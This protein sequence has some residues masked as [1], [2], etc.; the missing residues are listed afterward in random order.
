MYKYIFE[1][2]NNK[3]LFK[4]KLKFLAGTNL[5]GKSESPK[6]NLKTPDTPNDLQ[7]LKQILGTLKTENDEVNLRKINSLKKEITS[8]ENKYSNNEKISTQINKFKNTLSNFTDKPAATIGLLTEDYFKLEEALSKE[9]VTQQT[10]QDL[11]TLN[12]K[13]NFTKRPEKIDTNLLKPNTKVETTKR[14]NLRTLNQNNNDLVISQKNLP[15]GHPFTTTGKSIQLKN[16]GVSRTYIEVIAPNGDKGFII[17]ESLKVSDQQKSETS[18]T[19]KPETVEPSTASTSPETSPKEKGWFSETISKSSASKPKETKEQKEETNTEKINRLTRSIGQ[20]EATRFPNQNFHNPDYLKD[21]LKNNQVNDVDRGRIESSMQHLG[22]SYEEISDFIKN[23]LNTLPIYRLLESKPLPIEQEYKDLEK[24]FYISKEGIKLQEE[25]KKL[26]K[27]DKPQDKILLAQKQEEFTSK[28]RVYAETG[29]KENLNYY[30]KNKSSQSVLNGYIQTTR[31]LANSNNPDDQEQF[32]ARYEKLESAYQLANTLKNLQ[33]LEATEINRD[34]IEDVDVGNMSKMILQWINNP[35]SK[36]KLSQDLKD[37]I[38]DKLDTGLFTKK[39]K[40]LLL[41]ATIQLATNQNL[42]ELKR[43]KKIIQTKDGLQINHLA[44][45]NLE[46]DKIAIGLAYGPKL[47]KGV[48]DKLFD[49]DNLT[50]V[51]HKLQSS[52]QFETA[53]RRMYYHEIKN[54]PEKANPYTHLNV[55]FDRN[56]Y[57]DITKTGDTYSTVTR[58]DYNGRDKQKVE[59]QSVLRKYS[60]DLSQ[61]QQILLEVEENGII[62]EDKLLNKFNELIQLGSLGVDMNEQLKASDKNHLKKIATLPLTKEDLQIGIGKSQIELIRHG[63]VYEN[64][65]NDFLKN[66]PKSPDKS[67][68]KLGIP[69]SQVNSTY[70]ALTTALQYLGSGN[71]AVGK[72]LPAKDL[73][74]GWSLKPTGAAGAYILENPQVTVAGG[75]Q[76]K[77]TDKKSTFQVSLTGGLGVGREGVQAGVNVDT[78]RTEKITESLTVEIGAGGGLTIAGINVYGRIGFS[79]DNI[80][81]NQDLRFQQGLESMNKE[82][83]LTKE[84]ITSLKGLANKSDLSPSD[85]QTAESFFPSLAEAIQK[86]PQLK[87]ANPKDI[88]A[89]KKGYIETVLQAINNMSIE[90]A[91][92]VNWSVALTPGVLITPVGP[93]PYL[94]LGGGL[95]WGGETKVI[96]IFNPNTKLE[97]SQMRELLQD[98]IQNQPNKSISLQ[99]ND[100][101]AMHTIDGKTIVVKG[102]DKNIQNINIANKSES[103]NQLRSNSGIEFSETRQGY[104][105]FYTAKLDD[106]AKNRADIKNAVNASQVKIFVDPSVKDH[107]DLLPN[108]NASQEDKGTFRVSFTERSI[109]DNLVILRETITYPSTKG[110]VNTEVKISFTTKEHPLTGSQIENSSNNSS[111]LAFNRFG[112]GTKHEN[113]DNTKFNTLQTQGKFEYN[114]NIS[115]EE[116][117]QLGE[118]SQYLLERSKKGLEKTTHTPTEKLDELVTA[119]SAKPDLLKNLAELTVINIQKGKRVDLAKASQL[120]QSETSKLNIPQLSKEDYLYIYGNLMPN[121]YRSI[122]NL[123][124]KERET[125]I[126][127]LADSYVRDYVTSICETNTKPDGKKFTEQEKQTIINILSANSL[128]NNEVKKSLE[129][130]TVLTEKIGGPA[131]TKNLN[132]FQMFTT[133][134]RGNIRGLRN[135]Q[136]TPLMET[137]IIAGSLKKLNEDQKITPEDKQ[138]INEFML[139]MEDPIPSLDTTRLNF[140]NLKNSEFQKQI[141]ETL[142]SKTAMLMMSMVPYTANGQ[143]ISLL[144]VL[145][146]PETLTVINDIYKS[147]DTKSL[148]ETINND[149]S[150]LQTLKTL[151]TDIQ[152][153]HASHNS[154]NLLDFKGQ[155]IEIST[156]HESAVALLG[157]CANPTYL[158]KRTLGATVNY[159]EGTLAAAKANK[160]IIFKNGPAQRDNMNQI[161]FATRVEAPKPK[162]PTPTPEPEKPNKTPGPNP[163]PKP[164][165]P[166]TEFN[167]NNSETQEINSGRRERIQNNNNN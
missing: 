69:E 70:A 151:L 99:A 31:K 57:A 35:N 123:P 5:E 38:K 54:E 145:Y 87:E 53:K 148:S 153:V 14:E 64:L 25:I 48:W 93:V 18:K 85:I 154:V 6:E 164:E 128:V 125:A 66:S 159:Q 121:T 137:D 39:D 83:K 62:N 161:G 112:E 79:K 17:A 45:N 108:P 97:E 63:I 133:A 142:Q 105:G 16:N 78:S 65:R 77:K 46:L 51:V 157:T 28:Q 26:E 98:Q 156:Q 24:E 29:Y 139:S 44:F 67:L 100:V 160:N 127:K 124:V 32:R 74:D 20:Y 140:E 90:K 118:N 13:I 152:K 163:K 33:I 22:V 166:N 88:A 106:Y 102:T 40:N 147:I 72:S 11:Q 42:A 41:L 75:L 71:I 19:T 135:S 115:S 122:N 61:Y 82:A 34:K 130:S 21:L 120:I 52:S 126:N 107:I 86:D 101:Y 158:H 81:Q 150:K 113:K 59:N 111:Y 36:A 3:F 104:D 30:T 109:P 55:I 92:G 84:Q 1:K 134:H 12:S 136:I 138:I 132:G 4:H 10:Q 49:K 119:L 9:S 96:K 129:A 114:K 58:E 50:E 37:T 146:G 162:T 103:L 23:G 141:S 27:S 47:E 73:G 8:L 165:K 94:I 167:T 117:I 15:E 116:A 7:K 89:F 149:D 68:Q 43:G 91:E 131:N 76:L 95:E 2:Q 56:Y 80:G 144:G 143:S 110:G 60:A 155:P